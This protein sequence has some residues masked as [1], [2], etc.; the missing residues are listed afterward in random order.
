MCLTAACNLALHAVIM[1]TIHCDQHDGHVHNLGYRMADL[2]NLHIF[3]IEVLI[4]NC[5]HYLC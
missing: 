5:V 3:E 1:L 4:C 2:I